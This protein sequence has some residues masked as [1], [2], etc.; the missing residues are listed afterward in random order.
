M[1]HVNRAHCPV[2]CCLSQEFCQSVPDGMVIW[3]AVPQQVRKRRSSSRGAPAAYSST[4]LQPCLSFCRRRQPLSI[5]SRDYG[6][7]ILQHA[8]TAAAPAPEL[9]LRAA[10]A[11]PCSRSTC[12]LACAACSGNGLSR[13]RAQSHSIILSTLQDEG[14]WW[15]YAWEMQS[16]DSALQPRCWCIAVGAQNF[17]AS[18]RQLISKR[19]SGISHALESAGGSFH[20]VPHQGKCGTKRHSHHV[21]CS[22]SHCFKRRMELS[23][24]LCC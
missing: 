2:I 18:S 10:A 23:A 6:R 9:W 19:D 1:S 17:A 14:Y 5:T 13:G 12:S 7:L 21:F 16:S 22:L 15:V 20:R 8:T 24:R 4:C 11:T 3:S